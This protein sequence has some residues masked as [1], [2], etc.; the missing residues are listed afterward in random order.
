MILNFLTFFGRLITNRKRV[1]M[2]LLAVNGREWSR[3]R[4]SQGHGAGVA[5]AEIPVPPPYPAQPWQRRGLGPPG[6]T[7][8]GPAVMRMF[9]NLPRLVVGVLILLPGYQG[10][11]T[12]GVLLWSY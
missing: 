1:K 3:N 9:R 6:A 2:S 7:T 12:T 10:K 5:S 11:R 8:G 4:S